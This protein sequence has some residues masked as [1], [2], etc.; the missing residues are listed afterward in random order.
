MQQ[1]HDN[2]QAFTTFCQAMADDMNEQGMKYADKADY[3]AEDVKAIP[4]AVS[5]YMLTLEI[6]GKV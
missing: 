4:E 6:A 2:T 3:T 1:S 5:A